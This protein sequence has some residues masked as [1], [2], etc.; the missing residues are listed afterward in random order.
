MSTRVIAVI[1]PVYL[2]WL[3]YFE[4]IAYA[5]HFVFYDDV[6]YT[7]Q[8]WRNRN[9]ILG[10]SGPIWLTVPVKKATLNVAI[11]KIEIDNTHY[12]VS[13]HLKSIT[14][15]Y[16]R[17]DYF[18]HCFEILRAI[19]QQ[20]WTLLADLDVALIR[21]ICADLGI[22][23]TMSLSSA[24]PSDPEFV[25]QLD[26]IA[27]D[28]V[29]A[30]RNM[31]I[32]ELCR[33]H[34]AEVFYVGARASDYIDTDLFERFGIRVVFQRYVH[35]VYPQQ[36]AVAQSHMSVVDLLANVG[37]AARSVLLSSPPPALAR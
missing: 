8:D 33:H 27:A 37:P 1:Q 9:R 14:F 31:R 25:G 16:R 26:T 19:L 13:K 23:P 34:R 2:P 4:Q 5:D 18:D 35:P 12:W 21:A 15:N 24:L 36:H 6:Q 10:P 20:E 11:N 32:I 30:R 29:V 22:A 17:A 3:G 7:R 28:P